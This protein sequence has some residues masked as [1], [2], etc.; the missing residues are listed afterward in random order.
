MAWG[1]RGKAVYRLVHFL[2]SDKP[3]SLDDQDSSELTV[4]LC[5]FSPGDQEACRMQS[6]KH[7]PRSLVEAVI[8]VESP[9]LIGYLRPFSFLFFLN[10]LTFPSH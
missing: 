7:R 4:P 5:V 2:T 8:S 10:P 6:G 9:H 1:C 3:R